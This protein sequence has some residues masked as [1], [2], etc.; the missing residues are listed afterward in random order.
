MRPAIL[1]ALFLVSSSAWSADPSP[2][3]ETRVKVALALAAANQ[4]GDC[5]FDE[6]ACRMEAAA[7]GQ[8]L[9]LFIGGPACNRCGSAV[10]AAGGVP[11]V[12]ENYD[13]D[14]LGTKPRAVIL[15]P[16]PAGAGWWIGETLV[17]F[18][19][20]K[21]KT[22]VEKTKQKAPAPAVVPLNWMK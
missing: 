20:S 19:E 3:R 17:G 22:A 11:C 18:T 16:K 21:V 14:G 4:C 5:R 15:T 8:P 12:V 13:G 9:V 10:K 2:D 1:S 7:K 6:A